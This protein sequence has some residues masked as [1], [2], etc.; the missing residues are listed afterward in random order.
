M[1][2]LFLT[3]GKRLEECDL[4]ECERVALKG[5][6]LEQQMLGR[7]LIEVRKLQH[8]LADEQYR[9]AGTRIHR[10]ALV[11]RDL[12]IDELREKVA[13]LEGKT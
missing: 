9:Y 7:L 8:E 3:N 10:H 5:D 13:A 4:Q 11:C 12:K 6:S 1:D 2:L